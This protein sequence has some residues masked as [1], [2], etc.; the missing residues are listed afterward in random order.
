MNINLT[1]TGAENTSRKNDDSEYSIQIVRL[2]DEPPDEQVRVVTVQVGFSLDDEG[3]VTL[4]LSP[5]EA[6]SLGAELHG[7][8]Q[9]ALEVLAEAKEKS[10][11]SS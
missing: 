5:A 8:G 1:T 4:V 3:S 10:A 7:A 11:P 2:L 9:Q 6:V